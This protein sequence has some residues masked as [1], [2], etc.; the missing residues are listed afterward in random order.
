MT[1]QDEEVTMWD[2]AFSIPKITYTGV[3]CGW[4]L[5]ALTIIIIVFIIWKKTA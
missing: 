2:I 3:I 1:E 4:W 5:G